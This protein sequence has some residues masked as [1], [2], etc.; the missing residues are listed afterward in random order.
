MMDAV[1]L[2]ESWFGNS[3]RV[4]ERIAV[5]LRAAGAVAQVFRLDHADAHAP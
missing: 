4:A 3:R 5:G 2:H 1:A